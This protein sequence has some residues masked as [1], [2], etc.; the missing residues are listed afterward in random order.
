MLKELQCG[1]GML[2][3][4]TS[5]WA[6]G[7]EDTW[8]CSSAARAE[9]C[10]ALW[11]ESSPSEA[12]LSPCCCS[13][14]AAGAPPPALPQPRPRSSPT[15]LLDGAKSS[16]R[17]ALDISVSSCPPLGSWGSRGNGIFEGSKQPR[18]LRRETACR[19]TLEEKG[20]AFK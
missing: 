5:G 10:W 8:A 20:V 19:V 14:A 16:C 12:S 18:E 9:R 7:A 1:V 4:L 3:Y 15:V 13:A 11:A 6:M 2:S 17:L